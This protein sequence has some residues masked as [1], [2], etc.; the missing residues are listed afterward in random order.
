MLSIRK[1]ARELGIAVANGYGK[2]AGSTQICELGEVETPI[3]LT[4]T[5]SVPHAAEA[6]LDWSWGFREMKRLPPSTPWWVKPM[7]A[8]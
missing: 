8:V 2:L 7:T 6:V 5:L 1:R 3:V 4:N